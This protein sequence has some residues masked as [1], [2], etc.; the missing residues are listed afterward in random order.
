MSLAQTESAIRA[1]LPS[2]DVEW[3]KAPGASV[4]T[5]SPATLL[6]A[7]ETLRDEPELRFDLLL[8]GVSFGGQMRYQL[9][10]T[11][12][13]QRIRLQ[14]RLSQAPA[15]LPSLAFVWPA[16]AWIEREERETS[17]LVFTGHPDPEPL[18]CRVDVTPALPLTGS[19]D[20][21]FHGTRYLTSIDGLSLALQVRED[22]IASLRPQL[23]NRHV[24]LN[25]HLTRC[26]CDQGTT[27]AARLDGF[28]ALSCDL[29]YALAVEALLGLEVPPRAQ[30]LRSLYAELARLASHLF[31]L[32]RLIGDAAGPSFVGSARA[33]QG[34]STI[35]ELFERLGGN[36][37][38]PDLVAV[39]GLKQDAPLGFE[40]ATYQVTS[41]LKERLD[42]L[43]RLILNGRSIQAKLRGIGVIDAGT[44][45]GLGATGPC[46]R[47][48]GVAY[49]VRQ[50]FPYAAYPLLD[51][52]VP[53]MDAGDAA[54]RCQVRLAEMRGS[55]DLIQQC[56]ARL[57]DG[58]VN[59]LGAAG[60]P[61]E[62]PYGTAYA[63]VEGPRGELGV[64]AAANDSTHLEF[65]YIRGPS[66]AN[67]SALPLMA[68]GTALS[69]LR[70]LVDS[71]DLSAG[72]VER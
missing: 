28:A 24:R 30:V 19:R 57:E 70:L 34:R 13:E 4:L 65:A 58:P 20:T 23:G 53:T 50:A 29:A 66:F 63:A 59:T 62:V 2:A 10:S 35:L 32:A 52:Q 41:H 44:A 67:L 26:R 46:L 71:L 31:W 42:D 8:A 48:S 15:S 21:F 64:L 16:A 27:L 5:V 43:D 33:L 72:E 49:D 61:S 6:T 38:I 39:G 56:L 7:A 14:A 25:Q 12:H 9:A 51:L 45:V 11:S 22:Q 1:R 54:A 17:G 37:I 40:D 3:D 47:A 18:R 55:I 60:L 36:P 68:P 69:Q